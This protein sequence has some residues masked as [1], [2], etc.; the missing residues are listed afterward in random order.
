MNKIAIIKKGI[1]KGTKGTV[2]HETSHYVDIDLGFVL[3]VPLDDVTLYYSSGLDPRKDIDRVIFN[4]P[5]TIVWWKDG[6]KTV[7][8]CQDGDSFNKELGLAMAIVKKC[9]GNQGNYNDV[10]EKWCYT[11]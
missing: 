8:K 4:N 9:C 10:F 6:T 5:A 2:L 1:Y 3:R 11:E 7:V